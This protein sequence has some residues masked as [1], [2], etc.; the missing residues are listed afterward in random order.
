MNKIIQFLLHGCWHNWRLT[1]HVVD[2]FDMSFGTK[3]FMYR[4]HTAQCRKCG[5]IGGFKD[6]YGVNPPYENDCL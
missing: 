5:R 3:A 2:H 4:T 1:G 6:R